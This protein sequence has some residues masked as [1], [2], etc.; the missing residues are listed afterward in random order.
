VRSLILLHLLAP[1]DVYPAEI[2]AVISTHAAVVQSAVVGR[3]VEGNEEIVAFVQLLKGSNVTTQDPDGPYFAAAHLLQAA[4]R[5][6]PDGCVARDVDAPRVFS[7]SDVSI[8]SS[9]R[10]C[11]RMKSKTTRVRGARCRRDG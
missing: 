6:H 8:A 7:S 11:S 9:C 10:D 3:Q 1:G 2:E 5:D 4:V